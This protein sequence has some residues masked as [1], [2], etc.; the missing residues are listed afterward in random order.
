MFFL[1]GPFQDCGPVPLPLWACS[2]SGNV[3]VYREPV[4][5]V[6]SVS[7]S[8]ASRAIGP[9]APNPTWLPLCKLC[10]CWELSMVTHLKLTLVAN[11]EATPAVAHLTPCTLSTHRVLLEP[12][13]LFSP[14]VFLTSI[15]P[16]PFPVT[17]QAF[18]FSF[19]KASH[20]WAFSQSEC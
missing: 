15:W 2:W 20:G 14:S 1:C 7:R 9:A 5:W 13:I 11:S 8:S 12:V 19:H 16:P 6:S 3:R 10:T 17:Q 18:S 4:E